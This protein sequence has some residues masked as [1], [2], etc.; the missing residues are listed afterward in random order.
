MK[1]VDPRLIYNME[2]T[3]LFNVSNASRKV[4][5]MSGPLPV[6]Q[7]QVGERG[8][9]TTVCSASPQPCTS[10]SFILILK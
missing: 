5:A 2:E 10:S 7:I 8:T 3:G 1:D 4:L 6:S 9:L